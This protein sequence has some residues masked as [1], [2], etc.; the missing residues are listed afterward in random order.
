MNTVLCQEC[1]GV[2]EEEYI[3]LPQIKELPT[4]VLCECPN[5]GKMFAKITNL[6]DLIEQIIAN[7][8]LVTDAHT[9]F[10]TPFHE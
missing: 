3:M 10:Y 7:G 4:N 5:C 2:S 6:V 8:E 9:T 1:T